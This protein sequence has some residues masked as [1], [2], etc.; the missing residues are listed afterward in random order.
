[1]TDSVENITDVYKKTM[2]NIY[3][4]LKP[5]S[6]DKHYLHALASTQ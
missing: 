4:Q 3:R 5:M 1:M 2:H 6:F